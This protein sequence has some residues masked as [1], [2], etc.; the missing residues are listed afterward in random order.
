[1]VRQLKQT[2]FSGTGQET[3]R[4]RPLQRHDEAGG[5]HAALADHA[6]R[7]VLGGRSEA[8]ADTP[9]TVSIGPMPPVDQTAAAIRLADMPGV[10]RNRRNILQRSLVLDEAS[11]SG[12]ALVRH[13]RAPVPVGLNLLANVLK[14]FQAIMHRSGSASATMACAVTWLVWR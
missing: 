7:V 12:E 11:Q 1:M 3:P 13:P 9:E 10:D 8:A 5:P 6:S 4:R 14:T 2:V